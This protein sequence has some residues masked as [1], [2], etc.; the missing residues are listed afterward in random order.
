MLGKK[1]FKLSRVLFTPSLPSQ[2]GRGKTAEGLW[3]VH[4]PQGGVWSLVS[5]VSLRL[6]LE[7][8]FESFVLGTVLT[9]GLTD[10]N[11]NLPIIS[12]SRSLCWVCAP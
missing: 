9:T 12:T 10:Q 1:S 5:K 4:S 6:G 8:G 7:L 11:P 2:Q 3:G